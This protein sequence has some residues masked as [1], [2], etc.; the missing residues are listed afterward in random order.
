MFIALSYCSK[1]FVNPALAETR[2]EVKEGNEVQEIE[3]SKEG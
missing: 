2:E 1:P 3:E